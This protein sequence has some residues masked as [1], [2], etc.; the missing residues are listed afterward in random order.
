MR[1]EQTRSTVQAWTSNVLDC[2]VVYLRATVY[3]C[4]GTL[5][6]RASN[7]IILIMFRVGHLASRFSCR[8]IIP[9]R[10]HI[11]LSN[12]PVLQITSS[13]AWNATH[14]RVSQLSSRARP[15]P[16]GPRRTSFLSQLADQ[17]NRIPTKTVLWGVFAINGAVFLLWNVAMTQYVR[18]C[19]C[20]PA[21]ILTNNRE[22]MVIRTL[23]A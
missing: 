16:R 8:S 12:S 9:P 14:R 17:I 6:R 1:T 20:H 10:R 2:T 21:H 11:S 7:L 15:P 18:I 19:L 4:D 5:S 22:Q 23:S 13:R 3:T